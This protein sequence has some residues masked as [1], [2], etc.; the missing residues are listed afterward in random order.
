M[1]LEKALEEYGLKNNHA[2]IYVACLE[3]GSAP[4]LKIAQ[5]SG[6]ARS[7][8]EAVLENLQKRGFVSYF[9]KKG[10]KYYSVEDPHKVI[11]LAKEKA[12]TLERVLPQFMARYAQSK[13]NPRVRV[14]QGKQG[15][16]LVLKEILDEAKEVVAF[17]SA[18]DLF[19][20]IEEFTEFVKKRVALKIPVKVILQ[21]SSKA[22][23][24][25]QL[26]LQ[27]LRQV[28][29][30]PD[31]YNYHGMV[32]IWNHKVAMFSFTNDLTAL[33]I[34]SEELAKIQRAMFDLI[35]SSQ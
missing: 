28:K 31:S 8:C 11:S 9:R 35:W 16:K 3:L 7:T 12:Y 5:K 27:E 20:T 22:R 4:I 25:E 33:V 1:Q 6:F 21:N 32:L 24:R 23:E 19:I 18:E 2:K 30:I 15:M 13:T 34:E 17:S 14:F 29:I 10:V 26:G